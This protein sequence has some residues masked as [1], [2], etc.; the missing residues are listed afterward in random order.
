M[1]FRIAILCIA[2]SMVNSLYAQEIDLTD[3]TE[4]TDEM[5][6]EA[7]MTPIEDH[8]MNQMKGVLTP[9]VEVAD[10]ERAIKSYR[11]V[12]AVNKSA[13]GSDAQKVNVYENGQLVFTDKV[14]TG[15]EQVENKTKSGRVYFSTTPIG[16]YRP[17]TVYKDYYSNTWQAPMPNAVFFRGGIAIHAT[18]ESHYKEL[19]K[20]ASGGCVRLTLESSKLMREKIMLTGMG[21]QP[22]QYG[23]VN[24]GYKRNRITKNSIKV[25]KLARYT[26]DLL[27]EQVD[28]WD[29][30]IVVYE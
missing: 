19:G 1:K 8:I 23:I 3:S 12:I 16:F 21:N 9:K 2:I 20:R 11:L 24:E 18:T 27:K 22:G 25:D 13:S 4:L 7:G 5:A 10:V 15:R 29:T 26:G 14:S 30:V 6:L 17:V 28:S